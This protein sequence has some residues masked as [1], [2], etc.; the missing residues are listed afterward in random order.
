MQTFGKIVGLKGPKRAEKWP[1]W[2][3]RRLS[4]VEIAVLSNSPLF[5]YAKRPKFPFFRASGRGG[6]GAKT[7]ISGVPSLFP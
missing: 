2:V 7:A 6:G 3:Q 5:Y 1:K 4:C